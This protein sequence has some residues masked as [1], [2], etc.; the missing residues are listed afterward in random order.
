ML[1]PY[2]IYY[3]P[4]PIDGPR[5]ALVLQ[6][7]PPGLRLVEIIG[8]TILWNDGYLV[9]PTSQNLVDHQLPC[10]GRQPVDEPAEC[11]YREPYRF[12]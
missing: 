12:V 11:P 2:P 8:H 3:P 7:T 9:R 1:L 6:K 4:G 5:R 10:A